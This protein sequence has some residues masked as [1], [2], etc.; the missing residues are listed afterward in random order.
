MDM[1]RREVA[2]QNQTWITSDTMFLIMVVKKKIQS[3][4]YYCSWL[5]TPSIYKRITEF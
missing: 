1:K 4:I 5:E 2:N 3:T